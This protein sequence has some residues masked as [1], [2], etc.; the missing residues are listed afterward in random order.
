MAAIGINFGRMMRRATSDVDKESQNTPQH[1]SRSSNSFRGSEG[2][3]ESD[4]QMKGWMRKQ[5]ETLRS[6]PRRYFTLNGKVLTYFDSEDISRPPRGVIKFIDVSSLTTE[7]NGL[8]LHQASGKEVRLIA[9]TH[10]AY[11]AWL[12]VLSAALKKP[13]SNKKPSCKDGWAHCLIEDDVWTRYYIVVNNDGFS[14]FE[15]EDE[16]SE[17]ALSGLVR[18]VAEWD[19]KRFGLVVGLSKGRKIKLTFDST[20]EKMSW[21]LSLEFAVSF[22]NTRIKK[23]YTRKLA[24]TASMSMKEVAPTTFPG[25]IK[26]DADDGVWI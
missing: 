4:I 2:S 13:E 5:K 14:C 26:P 10:V 23:D 12:A 20:E 8:S 7:D 3:D 21:L 16:D 11:S 22:G 25:A 6:W 18:S 9:D 1:V 19:E 15:S 24:K 17:L